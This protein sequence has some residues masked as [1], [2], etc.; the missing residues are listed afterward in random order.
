[1]L[2]HLVESVGRFFNKMRD[3][4]EVQKVLF[5]FFRNNLGVPPG[6][7]KQNF[8][9]LKKE[10]LQLQKNPFEGRT[11]HHLDIIAWIDSRIEGKSIG[12]IVS[13]GL[14]EHDENPNQH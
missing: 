9:T 1:L 14:P 6:R 7:L 11:F 12:D 10:V 2:E 13:A 5:E 8:Q 4:N 3:L